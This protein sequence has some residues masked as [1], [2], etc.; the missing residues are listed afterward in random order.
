MKSLE[1][2]KPGDS[3]GR[4]ELL[5]KV[6]QG[7]MAAVWA[8]RLTGSRGFQRLVAIKTILPDLVDDPAFEQMFLDEAQ[9]ASRVQHPHVAQILDL[10]EQ[11]GVLFLVMEWVEGESL[12][13]LQ[14]A[15]LKLTGKPVPLPIAARII[16]QAAAGLHAAHELREEDGSP[17]ELVHR[18]VSPQN[19]LLSYKG[20][21]KIVDFG[22][23]KAMGRGSAETMAGKLKGKVPYMSPEQAIGDVIDR[24][25]DV[26]ALGTVFYQLALGK[27]PFR[28][29][30]DLET[31]NNILSRPV[32]PPR[33][34]DPSFPAELE[35]VVMK[36]I[37]KDKDER[38]PTMAAFEAALGAAIAR[39][40]MLT[41][42]SDVEA[43]VESVL[44]E[45][46]KK[47]RNS[48]KEAMR[49][50]DEQAAGFRE[51]S[52][53]LSSAV[54]QSG[55]SLAPRTLP[56]APAHSGLSLAPLPAPPSSS[57][58]LATPPS[59][60]GFSREP[61]EPTSSKKL[62]VVALA[63]AAAALIGLA[64]FAFLRGEPNDPSSA[65]AAE[66]GVDLAPLPT[67]PAPEELVVNPQ[68]TASADPEPAIDEPATELIIEEAA[69]ATPEPVRKAA[70]QKRAPQPAE[71]EKRVVPKRKK[72]PEIQDPGF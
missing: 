47:R 19:I 61:E 36:A 10:G 9:L 2:V 64:S 27:H 41:S 4:Y 72:V 6:A 26:F 48:L 49:A 55:L 62:T 13:I 14:K 24:R 22:I 66:P 67:E 60:V 65:T 68:P 32:L 46:A 17:V 69:P 37:A 23:A 39:L 31:M 63:I 28:G 25:T 52:F 57:P 33:A 5:A 54:T 70:S 44:G 21:V 50:A 11:D 35:E 12:S 34:I 20:S 58:R 42:D 30:G 56:E 59:L 51:T 18:D 40:G 15:S 38:F 1:D 43:F 8:A 29:D 16:M 45:R 53:T 71:V 7:G 3:L